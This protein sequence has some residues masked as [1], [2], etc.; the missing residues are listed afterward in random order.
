[1]NTQ[2][3]RGL[4][5]LATA[6]VGLVATATPAGADDDGP[7][8]GEGGADIATPGPVAQQQILEGLD[9]APTAVASAVLPS[10]DDFQYDDLITEGTAA[11][12]C[13][14]GLRR[15]TLGVFQALVQR[16]GG[17]S[18][19]MYSCRERYAVQERRECD[20]QVADPVTMPTFFSDCWSNHAQ[21]RAFDIMVGTSGGGYN[22]ARGNNIVNFLLASDSSGNVNANARRLGVQQILWNDRC[23]NSDGDRGIGSAAA[24]RVCGY[25]HFDHVHVDLSLDGSEARTSWWGFPPRRAPTLNSLW[26]QDT[27][28]GAWEWRT[29]VNLAAVSARSRRVLSALLDDRPR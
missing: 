25:G 11:E 8:P 21:G 15:G 10:I 29:L 28:S 12:V 3:R 27:A 13:H 7:R 4:V 9:E 2:T 26:L 16:F 18:G 19:T 20:G 5:A 22:Q 17:T 14:G 23:W 6:F 1:M 24:M